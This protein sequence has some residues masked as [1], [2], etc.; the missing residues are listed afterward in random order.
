[1]QKA[2]LGCPQEELARAGAGTA[3]HV[4]IKAMPVVG[5][6]R[7]RPSAQ[8]Q[9]TPAKRGLQHGLAAGDRRPARQTYHSRCCRRRAR[10]HSGQPHDERTTG[11]AGFGRPAS[12]GRV[13]AQHLEAER[14][15]TLTPCAEVCRRQDPHPAAEGQRVGRVGV[16][17]D[18]PRSPPRRRG[19]SGRPGRVDERRTAA[20]RGHHGLQVQR[21]RDEHAAHGVAE[22]GQPLAERWATAAAF[23]HVVR[24]RPGARAPTRRRRRA[25]PARR[26]TQ[27]SQRRSAVATEAGPPRAATRRRGEVMTA[28]S[29]RAR[30]PVSSTNTVRLW[31]GSGGSRRTSQPE[32]AALS[33]YAACWT[34]ARATSMERLP[35]PRLESARTR[36]PGRS[37]SA[38]E[39]GG[40]MASPQCKG[41]APRTWARGAAGGAR[42]GS[43]PRS[44][45]CAGPGSRR[46]TGPGRSRGRTRSGCRTPGSW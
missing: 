19:V 34:Q 24:R 30:S 23:R 3:A 39:G 27:R 42:S 38:G 13:D 2:I 22:R 10:L 12:S 15:H 26:R 7:P 45:S 46:P 35:G 17:K 32:R 21:A 33:S 37:G 5:G 29:S 6:R 41:A 11:D 20:D 25:C 14:A 1:M 4:A 43:R 28:T 9:P 36:L 18:R 40:L 16:R 44:R 31:S 8:G